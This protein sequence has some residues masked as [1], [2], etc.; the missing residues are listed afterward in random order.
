[1]KFISK[2]IINKVSIKFSTPDKP[3]LYLSTKAVLYGTNVAVYPRRK[4]I[5][6]FQKDL[7]LESGIIMKGNGTMISSTSK[8]MIFL[9]VPYK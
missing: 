4:I 8:S 3:T 5:T 1:M 2:S 9:D 6:T 7:N